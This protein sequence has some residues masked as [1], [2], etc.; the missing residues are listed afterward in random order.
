MDKN[1]CNICKRI[2]YIACEFCEDP[3]YFC[4]R[5][6][7]HSHKLKC[8]N[9]KKS[10]DNSFSSNS[11]VPSSNKSK[12]EDLKNNEPQ[13]DMRKLFQHLQNTKQDVEI[14]LKNNNFVD[15]IL[16]IGKCLSLSRKFYEDDHLF[17]KL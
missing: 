14:K 3:L 10:A 1:L 13:I 11:F 4:S 5:G 2:A 16:G 6:H 9:N 12:H 8:H 17:V 7:L 15:A